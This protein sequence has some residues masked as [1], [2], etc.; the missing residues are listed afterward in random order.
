M[1]NK[2]GRVIQIVGIDG[3]RFYLLNITGIQTSL[4]KLLS[5]SSLFFASNS[6]TRHG[7]H[8][9]CDLALFSSQLSLS[10]W[11]LSQ[12]LWSRTVR[13]KRLLFTSLTSSRYSVK[14]ITAWTDQAT[15]YSIHLLNSHHSFR[16]K[17]SDLIVSFSSSKSCRKSEA[18]LLLLGW[19]QGCWP[20]SSSPS[21]MDEPP[22][23]PNLSGSSP[24]T[25]QDPTPVLPLLGSASCPFSEVS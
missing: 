24:P 2:K 11:L 6:S 5:G 12:N 1:K 16:L 9:P 23:S 8:S 22:S 19:V 15:S 17:N 18:S 20:P 10:L 14:L 7:I 25:V 4:V 13:N 3:F 21:G